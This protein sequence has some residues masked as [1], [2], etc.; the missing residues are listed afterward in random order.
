MTL[1]HTLTTCTKITQNSS[2]LKHKTWHHRIPRRE[3]RKTISYINHKSVFLGQS[4]KATEIKTKIN[5]SDLLKLTSFCTVKETI[6][7]KKKKKKRQPTM[8]EK[9]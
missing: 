1:E 5:K 9:S 6:K 3:H 4:P 7:K 8:G 2:R